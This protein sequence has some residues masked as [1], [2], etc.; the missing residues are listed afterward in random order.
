MS[1]AKPYGILPQWTRCHGLNLK[2]LLRSHMLKTWLPAD[3]L[4]SWLDCKGSHFISGL[5]HWQRL[6]LVTL[7]GGC[8]NWEAG[9]SHRKSVIDGT[10]L[11]GLSWS[12]SLSPCFLGCR[13][14]N[15]CPVS[16]LWCC[17]LVQA[18]REGIKQLCAAIPTLWATINLPLLSHIISAILPQWQKNEQDCVL[19]SLCCDK[20]AWLK[21]LKSLF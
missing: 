10:S 19:L 18:H 20:T 16:L 13:P 8:G 15:S 14:V 3:R 11:E 21:P 9:R 5:I 1:K 4:W 7:M 6:N 2:C 12:Y 17:A